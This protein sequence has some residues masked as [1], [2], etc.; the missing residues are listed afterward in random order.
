VLL[1]NNDNLL[2]LTTARGQNPG[3]L[4]ILLVGPSSDSLSYQTG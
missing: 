3:W 2:P 4:N 1:K